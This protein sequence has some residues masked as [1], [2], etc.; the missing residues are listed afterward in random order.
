M[1]GTCPRRDGRGKTETI[2]S[3]FGHDRRRGSMK[4]MLWAI[5]LTLV[6][7][8]GPTLPALAAGG[9]TG[10]S[11]GGGAGVRGG[12]SPGGGASGFRGG[13]AGVRGGG[14]RGGASGFHAGGAGWAGGGYRG[15]ASGRGGGYYGGGVYH[16]GGYHGGG[17][18]YGGTRVV[19]GGGY[20]WWGS[21]GWWGP[22]WWGTSYPYY[23][24][25]PVV[26]QQAP[27]EYIQLSPAPP[28]QE[29]WYYCQSAGAYYPYVKECPGGWM[30][31]VP[32]PTSPGP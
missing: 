16:G 2:D 19:V 31:V 8:V 20:G 17:G 5:G 29:Y 11:P 10:A 13:G 22:G 12:G 7:V 18:W 28:E 26:V 30:Q 24:P 1:C 15:G 3:P 25:A 23:A 21:P 9:G 27:T 6:L 14:Y 4:Q 32:Q